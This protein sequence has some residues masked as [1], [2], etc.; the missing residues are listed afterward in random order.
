MLEIR[1][2]LDL[3]KFTSLKVGDKASYFVL[4]K[5]LDDLKEAHS[6]AC[7]KK[8][9]IFVLG[10]GTNIL[11]SRPLNLLVLKNEIKGINIEKET[12]NHVY[13]RANSGEW[14][15]SL[16]D[17]SVAKN[18]GG[19]ENLY[20]VPGTVGAAPVQNIGAYG[21]E[22][23]DSLVSLKAYDF[24][25]KKIKEFSNKDCQF[26]YRNSI[27][28]TKYKNRFFILSILVKLDKKPK[29]QLDYGQIKQRLKSSKPS[30]KQVAKV[31]KEI[32]D[33]KLPN[34]AKLPNAGSF[35]KNPEI[36]LADFKKLEKKYPDI[37]S[38][39]ASKKSLIKVPAGWLIEKAGF[40]GK[41]FGPV[42]MYEKQA[43]ILVN[44]DKAKAKDVL[45]LVKKVKKQVKK[46]FNINLE[47]EVVIL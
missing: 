41:R 13:I 21:R 26:S 2:N 6:I 25:T 27:F 35:F 39:Q 45:N 1:E 34:P 36:K 8:L 3:T 43:L 17:F 14:W 16:V 5:N 15:S 19:L 20:Y 47:E 29:L 10:G 32:R 11:I 31:I 37:V 22:L 40:K 33:E 18:L 12:K 38:F 30:T 4:V 44:Y 24:K 9:D 7:E 23:K 42:G 46:K 28:K